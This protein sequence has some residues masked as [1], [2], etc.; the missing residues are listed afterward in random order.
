MMSDDNRADGDKVVSFPVPDEERARRLKVE[1]ERLAR[2]S[3]TEWIYYVESPG[4][5]EKYGVDK[6]VLR[7]MIEA[8]VKAR[9]SNH[10]RRASTRAPERM[11]AIGNDARSYA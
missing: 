7:Q 6:A 4:Y 11:P 3:S 9:R 8:T 10:L 2:Q 5:A 1:V